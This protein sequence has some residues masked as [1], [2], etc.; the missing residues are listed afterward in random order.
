VNCNRRG[1]FWFGSGGR[2]TRLVPDLRNVRTRRE[3]DPELGTV[4][5]AAIVLQ[6]PP[7][8]VAGRDPYDRIF[9]RIV[10]RRP[11]KELDSDHPLFQL[12]DR[13]LESPLDNMAE[14]LLAAMAAAE[15]RSLRQF[16][17]MMLERLYPFRIAGQVADFVGPG[18]FVCASIH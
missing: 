10:R 3:L 1:R 7:A 14:K 8:H 9:A 18:E 2:W 15:G 13:A 12:I 5:I 4:A 6:Q 11:L 17:Q 16:V